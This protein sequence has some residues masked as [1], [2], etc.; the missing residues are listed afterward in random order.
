[1]SARDGGTLSPK[2][3]LL[4]AAKATFSVGLLVFLFRRIPLDQFATAVRGVAQNW[5]QFQTV[6]PLPQTQGQTTTP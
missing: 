3:A 4:V 1:M 2:H 5:P 6:S